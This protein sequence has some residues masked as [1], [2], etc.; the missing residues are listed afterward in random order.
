LIAW[1]FTGHVEAA[2]SLVGIA[3]VSST[4]LFMIHEKAWETLS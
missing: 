1:F 3:A 2:A 4:V